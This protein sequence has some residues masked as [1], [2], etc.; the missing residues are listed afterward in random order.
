[1]TLLQEVHAVPPEPAPV[2][3][4]KLGTYL[5]TLPPDDA[6]DLRTKLRASLSAARLAKVLRSPDFKALMGYTVDVGATTIKD[7][8]RKECAC[9][10]KVTNG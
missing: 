10:T 2:S 5:R 6:F 1:M 7:H 4:C 9:Y 3:E 8:R